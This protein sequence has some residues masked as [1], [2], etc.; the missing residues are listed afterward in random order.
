MATDNQ[1]E[2][3]DL[4]VEARGIDIGVNELRLDFDNSTTVGVFITLQML[5]HTP[6]AKCVVTVEHDAIDGKIR[7]ASIVE[8]SIEFITTSENYAPSLTE[9]DLDKIVDVLNQILDSAGGLSVTSPGGTLTGIDVQDNF[10]VLNWSEPGQS[11]YDD[12][13]VENRLVDMV[14]TLADKAENFLA[15]GED[16]NWTVDVTIGTELEIVAQFTAFDTT[17]TL[18]IALAFD[19]LNVAVT[20]AEISLGSKTLTFDAA[21]TAGCS[22]YIPS[23][24]TSDFTLQSGP[25]ELQDFI[26]DIEGSLLDAID[27]AV[28]DIVDSTALKFP[29]W[30]ISQIAV[31]TNTVV[32]YDA[33]E[34]VLE[35]PLLRGWNMVSVPFDPQPATRADVFPDA[36][37]VWAWDG[38][39]YTAVADGDEILA[40]HGYWV[41]MEID[42]EDFAF[43]GVPLGADRTLDLVA[44]WNMVGV[45]EDTLVGDLAIEEDLPD[46]LQ[47]DYI[48]LWGPTGKS[49]GDPVTTLEP[50][51]AY[52]LA[53]TDACTLV[54]S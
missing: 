7:I 34:A 49:Y 15:T 20:G 47:R 21:G 43:H 29:Y 44:G 26:A 33:G 35:V 6:K 1:M 24:S 42:D 3:W 54:L 23:L 19:M 53:S 40:C 41:R 48:Y 52:W 50:G 28:A 25:T 2:I 30:S 14:S 31:E 12:E 38:T 10:L 39:A 46:A 16:V 45:A 51:N 17:A 32:L 18:D 8:D 4:A 22:N 5:G 9:Q 36:T 27:N 11:S 37:D 13:T